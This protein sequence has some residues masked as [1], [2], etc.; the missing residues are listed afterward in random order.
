MRRSFTIDYL[1]ECMHRYG[2]EYAVVAVDV[3]RAT[4]TAVTAVAL[5]RRCYPVPTIEA[6]VELAAKI[7]EGLL[8]GELGGTIPYGFDLDNSPVPLSG[9]PETSRPLILLS[10]SGTRVICGGVPGQVMYAASLRNVSAQ[11]ERLVA[12]DP[13]VALIGAGARGEFRSEDALCCA[14]IGAQLMDHGYVPE[15]EATTAVID[16]WAEAATEVIVD[17]PS[18]DYLRDTGRTEDIR[19]VLQHVDDLAAHVELVDG[20]LVYRESGAREN[21]QG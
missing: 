17:G 19:F 14:R 6:A 9:L 3:F 18:A 8:A 4:T 2:P 15:D 12:H 13:R 20:E 21:P 1:P 11:V 16:R 10:T 5:G 7:P